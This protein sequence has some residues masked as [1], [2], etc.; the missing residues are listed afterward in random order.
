[1]FRPWAGKWVHRADEVGEYWEGHSHGWMRRTLIRIEKERRYYVERKAAKKMQK[2]CRSVI[3]WAR[4]DRVVAYKLKVRKVEDILVLHRNAANI[5]GFFWVRRRE[6][7]ALEDRF[8]KRRLVLD[9]YER[10]TQL[11]LDAFAQRDEAIEQ[12]NIPS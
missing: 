10:L 2:F 4:F 5:I 11:K 12:V 3:A 8:R 9:E 6:K 7:Y 1:L